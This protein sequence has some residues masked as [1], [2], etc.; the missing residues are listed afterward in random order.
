MECNRVPFAEKV[1]DLTEQ[2]RGK[3]KQRMDRFEAELYQ[4]G[5]EGGATRGAA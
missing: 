2:E 4:E 5:L 1:D 3:L